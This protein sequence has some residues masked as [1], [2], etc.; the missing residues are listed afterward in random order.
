VGAPV[1]DGRALSL[2][3]RDRWRGRAGYPYVR[4]AGCWLTRTG[5]LPSG[6]PVEV[7][8][9]D[10]LLA[11]A[12]GQLDAGADLVKLYMDGPDRDTS[13]FTAAEV[14]RTVEAVHARGA[15]VTAHSSLLP[16]PG[17]RLPPGWTR[18]SM[19]SGSTRTWRGPWP[20]RG[21][22]WCRRWR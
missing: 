21:R 1:R 14:R 2:T 18:W 16:A 7:E 12:L 4:A 13:P 3:V 22:C 10:G 9:G 19:G 17:R 15:T 8:D 11:A 20:P 6:L 5:S